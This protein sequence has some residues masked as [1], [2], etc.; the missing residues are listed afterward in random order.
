MSQTSAAINKPLYVIEAEKLQSNAG[1]WQAYQSTG[2]CV[3]LAGPGSGKTKTLTVKMARMLSE[4]VKPPRGI[5]CITYSKE[6]VRELKR[7]LKQLNISDGRNTSIST[8]HGFC[9]NHIVTPYAQIAGI[10]KKYPITVPSISETNEIKQEALN[11]SLG[12]GGYWDT[13]FDKYRRTILERDTDVWKHTNEQAAQ[14][15]DNYEVLLE[16]K[17]LIDFDGMVLMGLKLA[18]N[19]SWVRKALVARFPILVVDEYQD[20]GHPLDRLVRCLCFQ[21]GMRLLAVGDPDQSIYGFTGANPTLLKTLSELKEVEA[22]HLKLNYRCGSNII[23]AS[24]AA[25]SEKREFQSGHDDPGLVYIQE[26]PE[27]L[28]EQMD[29]VCTTIIPEAIKRREGR[30]LGDIAI[31]YIDKNDGNVVADAVKAKGWSFVRVD[32]NNPYQA[33]TITYWL[34]DCAAWCAGEWKKGTISLSELINRWIAFNDR[35]DSSDAQRQSRMQLIKFLYNHRMPDL[36][37][38][39]WLNEFM[40]SGLKELINY[41]FRLKDDKE[42]V[43]NLLQVTSSGGELENATVAFFGGQGGS[44]EHLSLTTL[45]SSKGLEYDVVIIVGLE[46]GRLPGYRNQNEPFLS[47]ERRKFYVGLTR[48]R[49]EVHLLYSGHY[50]TLSRRGPWLHNDGRSQFIDEVENSIHL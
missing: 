31:L 49:H 41:E 40:N 18:E 36:E 39:A 21:G 50:M 33:S 9:L 25:L 44:P 20:L 19:F 4:D 12:A 2:N 34:E 47:E 46:Q 35:F 7:R 5:A 15:I 13:S 11:N 8:L 10:L 42:K 1:Q 37:L 16:N 29:Y 28:Q 22:V 38:H 3:L 26:C 32:N 6:C 14:V 23:E 17:G 48:A 43:E 27:G 45:H 30:K 24:K